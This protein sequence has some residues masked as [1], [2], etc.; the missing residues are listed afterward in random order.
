MNKNGSRNEIITESI[1][2]KYNHILYRSAT[3]VEN[4]SI[5]L[6]TGLACVMNL[7][8]GLALAQ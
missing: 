8:N 6:P 2:I 7:A 3:V 4:I 1:D 5:L